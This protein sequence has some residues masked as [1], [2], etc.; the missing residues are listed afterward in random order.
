MPG[1]SELIVVGNGMV[2]HRFVE[3]LI[4]EGRTADFRIT[5]IGEET[6]PAYDRVG[7][8]SYFAGK[9][10]DDLSLVEP[11][12]YERAGIEV[13]RGDRVSTIDR[14]GKT[15]TLASGETLGYD[16]LVLATGSYAFVPPVEGRNAPGAFVYRTIDDLQAMEAY[17]ARS[18]VGVVIGGGLLGLE[19]AN[20]LKNLA[21]ETHVVEL[22]PRLMSLQ[23]DDIGGAVLRRRIEA[24]GVTVHLGA[25]TTRVITNADGAVTALLLKDGTELPADMVVFSAGIRAR[26]ELARASGLD[27]GERGGIEIDDRCRTSD[28]SI[29]AIGECAAYNDRVYGLVAPGYHMARVAASALAGHGGETFTGYDMST[30]LKLMGVDVASFGDAFAATHGAHVI[31]VVDT[32]AEVYKKL[33]ISP[34][35]QHLLGGVL[36]GDAA[37]YGQLVQLVQNRIP[38]PP[39]PEDLLMPPREGGKPSGFG[40]DS[41]PDAAQICSCNNVSKGQICG[42]IGEK[43]LTTVGGIKECTKAGTS[44]G[45]C[46]T[47][48]SEILT[49]ELKKA[50]VV[51][52]KRLCEHFDHSRQELYHLV[53]LHRLRTFEDLLAQHGAGRGCEICKPAVASI[54][55]S[56]WNEHILDRKH[57]PLQD[58]NDRFLANIQRD[59]TYSV[60]PRVAGRRD[61]AGEADRARRG[62]EEATTFTPRSPVASASICSARG[63]SSCPRSGASW[64]R[65]ASNPGTRTAR[66]CAP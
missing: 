42:A 5:V 17:A 45:S 23:I 21:L 52:S 35:K 10:A 36:V 61:H 50:G 37:N 41:L 53:R 11:G 49:K 57:L 39:H 14:D 48:V 58:S 66:R 30:K 1:R 31:S 54:L 47:L 13:R 27:L 19:A 4:S 62:R 12:S 24:L 22:A 2:G 8:S 9:T 40:V 3:L 20:A 33:V 44:C 26:D 55:A 7:L 28:P 32:L 60:V 51:V 29:Y 25:L 65:R 59:G 15:V 63:S 38:L 6:R 56:A 46:V 18:K 34:D 16:Q 43:K 64:S